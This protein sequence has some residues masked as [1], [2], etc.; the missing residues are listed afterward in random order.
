MV[1][2]LVARGI[3]GL[4]GFSEIHIEDGLQVL[5]V[6]VGSLLL[7]MSTFKPCR[8]VW[9]SHGIMGLET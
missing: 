3:P 2:Q 7:L 5:L 8:M 9:I 1:A 6:V 4:V